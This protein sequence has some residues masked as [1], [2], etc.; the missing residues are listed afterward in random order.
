MKL[1]SYK[2]IIKEDFASE[3]QSLISKLG[4]LLNSAF[5]SIFLAFDKNITI[6]DN[7][8]QDLVDID[9]SVDANGYPRQPV[10]IRTKLRNNC[11]GAMVVRVD[12]LTNPGVYVPLAPFVHFEQAQTTSVRITN[13]RGLTADNKYRVKLLL[14]GG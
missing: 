11:K 13:I 8:N 5:D 4:F 10:E 9:V 3:E 14:L 2:R 7:L 12:N 6:A 1:P